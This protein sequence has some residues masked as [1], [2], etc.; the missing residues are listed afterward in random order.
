ML[1]RDLE[2]FLRYV[3]TVAFRFCY[4]LTCLLTRSICDSCLASLWQTVRT[5][6]SVHYVEIKKRVATRSTLKACCWQLRVVGA[7]E[8][9]MMCATSRE[10]AMT[11]CRVTKMG[12][13]YIS[14]I[15]QSSI[16]HT[17]CTHDIMVASTCLEDHRG[18]P[19]TPP[20]QSLWLTFVRIIKLI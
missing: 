10:V 5:Q 4:L 15:Q 20:I 14:N 2:A 9:N 8:L 18:K 17:L 16:P 11:R 6:A 19:S 12:F 3:T 13:R 7:E 1:L